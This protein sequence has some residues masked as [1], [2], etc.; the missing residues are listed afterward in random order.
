M[1]IQLYNNGQSETAAIIPIVFHLG[2]EAGTLTS[3]LSLRSEFSAINSIVAILVHIIFVYIAL[4]NSDRIDKLLG[5]QGINVLKKI[6]WS[7][8]A[9]DSCK[10]FCD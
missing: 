10:T 2:T 7:Y 4:K 9:C 8:L 6:F 3:V 1:A 5:K